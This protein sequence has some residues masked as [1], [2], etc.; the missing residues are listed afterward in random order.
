[1]QYCASYESASRLQSDRRCL[2]AERTDHELDRALRFHEITFRLSSIVEDLAR[3]PPT[4]FVAIH[5]E[6]AARC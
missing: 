4:E 5:G 2:D 3:R 6:R 1:M